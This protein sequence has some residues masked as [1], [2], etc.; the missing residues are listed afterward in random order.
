MAGLKPGARLRAPYARGGCIYTQAQCNLFLP[1]PG[2]AYERHHPAI[3]VAEH[4]GVEFVG[5]GV[6]EHA[7]VQAGGP[8]EPPVGASHR[9]GNDGVGDAVAGALGKDAD[10]L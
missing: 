7:D 4:V 8:E 6:S 3:D 5:G 2:S 10:S 9:Q 1:N